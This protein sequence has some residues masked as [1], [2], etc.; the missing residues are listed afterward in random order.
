MTVSELMTELLRDRPFFEQSGGG[1]TFSGGEPL[2]QPE[3][4][5]ASLQACRGH[6]LHAAVDT[7]GFA[8]AEQLVELTAWTD[9]FLFDLK[10]V[11]DTRHREHTGVSVK[12]ILY[13]LH[14]LDQAGAAIRV[15]LPLIPGI[16]DD[17]DNLEAIAACVARLDNTRQVDLLPYHAVGETKYLRLGRPL[18]DTT[19]RQASSAQIEAAARRL[20]DHGLEVYLSAVPR[21]V[22]GQ[23]ASA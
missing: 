23:E 12:P 19:I 4:L 17:D 2:M 8:P 7:S 21:I 18:P 3:F 5:L 16:N 13:N 10:L 9:L 14:L 15:R 1:V 20:A 11:D 22:P 6:G